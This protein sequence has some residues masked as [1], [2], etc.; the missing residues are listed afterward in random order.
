MSKFTVDPKALRTGLTIAKIVKP[1]LQDYS[2]KITLEGMSIWSMDRKRSV[3]AF[4]PVSDSTLVADEEFFLPMDRTSLL[5]TDFSSCSWTINEKGATVK[6]S[7]SGKSKTA[8]LKRRAVNAR[9]PLPP[10]IPDVSGSPLVDAKTFSRILNQ[11][12]ASA[13]VKQTKT[14]EDARINQ[15][16]FYGAFNS[17]T[18]NARY[19]AT[20][21]VNPLITFDL[22]IVSSDIPLIEQFLARIPGD[23]YVYQDSAKVYFVDSRKLNMLVVAKVATQRPEFKPIDI[24]DAKTVTTVNCEEFKS[25][26]SWSVQAIDG[27]PRATIKIDG[28]QLEMSYNLGG[29]GHITVASQGSPFSADFPVSVLDTVFGYFEGAEFTL[30][31]NLPKA[32]NVMVWSQSFSDSTQAWHY[33][34][35]MR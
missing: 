9:R 25:L 31:S 34:A 12:S 26:I 24:A 32:P 15:I 6:Y 27:T 22:S 35:S 4:V 14:D 13:Q 20:C 11:V 18:S 30:H 29:L 33:I 2:I 23:V 1:V 21:V 16:H 3:T 8:S 10:P 19:Y 17:V 7:E 28:S 5:E